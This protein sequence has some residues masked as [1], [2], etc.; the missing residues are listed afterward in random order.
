MISY[1]VKYSK[2]SVKF[3][4]NNK[5]VGLKFFQAFSEIAENTSNINLYDIK[6]LK[7]YDSLKRLRIGKYRAIFEII[8][9]QI[10]IFVLDIDS[11]GDIY[12][13]L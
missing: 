9:N 5:K 10:V 11:R 6:N 2:E 3:M 1:K 4:K 13:N 8:E 7:G 12:K